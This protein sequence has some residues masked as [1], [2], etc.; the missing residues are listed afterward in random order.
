MTACCAIC[1]IHA[2]PKQISDFEICRTDLWVV[3]HHVAPAPLLGWLLLDTLR[4]CGG[5]VDF[6]EEEARSWGQ[7]VQQASH[8]VR[9]L[10]GCDRV[11]AIAFGEG[12]QHLHLHLIPRF[13]SD[14]KTAAWSVADHYR[15]VADGDQPGVERDQV[16][17][18]VQRARLEHGFQS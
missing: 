2:D 8:L 7:A 12:A 6:M 17:A 16:K 9:S 4:H 5:P 13:I 3:R 14:T 11:Y 18:F 1:Q 15:A 10:T